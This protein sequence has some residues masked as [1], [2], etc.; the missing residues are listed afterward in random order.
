M[1]MYVRKIRKIPPNQPTLNIKKLWKEEQIPELI[2]LKK[3]QLW[4]DTNEIDAK[5]Q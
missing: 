2:E 5:R 1:N 3:Y 4:V